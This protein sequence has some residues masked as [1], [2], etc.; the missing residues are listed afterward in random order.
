MPTRLRHWLIALLGVPLLL[1]SPTTAWATTDPDLD[2]TVDADEEMISGRAVIDSGHV[3]LGPRLIDG[4]WTLQARD[5]RSTPPVWRDPDDV[6]FH[7]LDTAILQAPENPDFDFIGVEPGSDV[8][9]IPQT[10]LPE[11]VWL[12]WNTQ[13]PE[14]AA[15]IGLG[16]SL[17]LHEVHGPGEIFLF[18]QEGVSGP[19]NVLWR[20]DEPGPQ[21]LWME[22]GTHTHANWVFTEPGLYQ[23]LVEVHAELGGE[24][25]VS[26]LATL[27]FAVGGTSPEDAFELPTITPADSSAVPADADPATGSGPLLPVLGGVTVLLAGLAVALLVRSRRGRE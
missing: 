9:V 27:R 25:P 13:D 1:L 10:Q 7:V 22:V 17:T 2:Q 5:D 21:S 11:V 15:Q 19:P 20:S 14:V 18:L 4:V 8:H 12:G 16:A 26:D 3:D 6:V 24:K 23:V